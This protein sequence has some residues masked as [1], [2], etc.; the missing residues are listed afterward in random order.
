MDRKQ[1]RRVYK[2]MI[3]EWE[4]KRVYSKLNDKYIYYLIKVCSNP[5]DDEITEVIIKEKGEV[6][7]IIPVKTYKANVKRRKM[8]RE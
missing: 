5:K 2:S 8:D 4:L 1:E 3:K 6:V 7:E